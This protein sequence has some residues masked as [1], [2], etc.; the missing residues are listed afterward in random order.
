MDPVTVFDISCWS[1]TTIVMTY[2]VFTLWGY[3]PRGFTSKSKL[4]KQALEAVM[5][6]N[7]PEFSKELDRSI[8]EQT[9]SMENLRL[10]IR[11]VKDYP[12]VD[13]SVLTSSIRL[14]RC[15]LRTTL[16]TAN[17]TAEQLAM[18][19]KFNSIMR[20]FWI[21]GSGPE[22][23]KKRN[24]LGRTALYVLSHMDKADDVLNVVNQRKVYQLKHIKALM[25]AVDE[26]PASALSDGML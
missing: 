19:S 5:E 6:S 15:K 23:D 12:A 10:F 2:N 9:K 25:K 3:L 7:R 1:F 21:D 26:T 18:W 22:V 4:R 8:V 14:A 17:L 11:F 13:L 20:D 16:L 24:D